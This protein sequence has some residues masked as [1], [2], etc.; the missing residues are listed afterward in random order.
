MNVQVVGSYSAS[1]EANSYRT[2][3][4]CFTP[5]NGG[6]D[7]NFNENS[8][9]K[10]RGAAVNDRTFRLYCSQYD[11][12]KLNSM[13]IKMSPGSTGDLASGYVKFCSI[14][15]RKTTS[16][17]EAL[18]SG[19]LPTAVEIENNPG[20][21]VTP[22]QPGRATPVMR[23]VYASN[24][25]EKSNYLDSTITYAGGEDN[26]MSSM[27]LTS[28]SG[29][30]GGYVFAPTFYCFLRTGVSFE[31]STHLAI[32]YTVEYNFTFRNPK[33][34]IEEFMANEVVSMSKANRDLALRRLISLSS[35]ER[36]SGED[37][38]MKEEDEDED[39]VVA[40]T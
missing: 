2:E 23:S 35:S 36:S 37:V 40:K 30:S 21:I 6:I 29:Q 1:L 26:P 3:V 7:G 12:V 17:E 38:V 15:D 11:E 24:L 28:R 32:T 31:A 34:S 22:F 13:R 16:S 20:V 27:Y 39:G 4:F 18:A 33:N 9:R 25:A 14:V 19:D 5:Y 8:L 10:Y